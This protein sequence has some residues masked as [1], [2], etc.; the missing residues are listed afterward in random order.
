MNDSLGIMKKNKNIAAIYSQYKEKYLEKIANAHNLRTE[1]VLAT[2][3]NN[4]II[5]TQRKKDLLKRNE[6]L[7]EKGRLKRMEEMR[8]EKEFFIKYFWTFVIKF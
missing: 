4:R 7:K 3:H 5:E 1:N 6:I 2:Y 8:M